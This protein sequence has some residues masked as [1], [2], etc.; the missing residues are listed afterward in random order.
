MKKI[1]ASIKT[2]IVLFALAFILLGF[3]TYLLSRPLSYGMAYQGVSEVG[4]EKFS[5]SMTFY[6]DGTVGVR[7]ANFDGEVKSRYYYKD[8]Y[9]FFTLAETDEEYEQEI[10]QINENFD[11]MIESPF[12]AARADAFGLTYGGMVDCT[13]PSVVLLLVVCGALDLMLIALTVVSL[14]LYK[15]PTAIIK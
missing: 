8:G 6:F 1:L 11:D 15:K 2:L 4:G 3:C 7:N 12:Y 10:A 14:A 9:V 13:C 5:V